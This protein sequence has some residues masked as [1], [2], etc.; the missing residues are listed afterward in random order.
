MSHPAA[1]TPLVRWAPLLACP[2]A[3]VGCGLMFGL[4]VVVL[5][6]ALAVAVSLLPIGAL[7]VIQRPALGFLLVP[8]T[9]PVGAFGVP[10]LGISTT[11]FAV[12]AAT[13][14]VS[15]AALLS[16]VWPL[17]FERELTWAVALVAWIAVATLA[18]PDLFLGVRQTAVLVAGLCLAAAIATT[19]STRDARTLLAV[20]LAIGGTICLVGVRGTSQLDVRYGGAVVLGRA[21]GIFAQ[22]ND[23][24]IFSAVVFFVALG[25]FFASRHRGARLAAAGLA[26]GSATG[27][28]LSLSRGTWIGALVGMLAFLVLMPE[29][30]RRM[31]LVGVGAISALVALTLVAP[32]FFPSDAVVDRLDSALEGNQNPY[33]TRPAIWREGWRQMTADPVFG[34]G[35][36]GF[37]TALADSK[38]SGTTG[39]ALHA[40]NVVLTVGAE[41][42]LPAVIF[43]V[44]FTVALGRRSVRC[45]RSAISRRDRALAA[46]TSSALVAVLGQGLVDFTLRNPILLGSLWFLIGVLLVLTRTAG[47][48]ISA[49]APFQASSEDFEFTSPPAPGTAESL[50]PAA[51]GLLPSVAP[52]PPPP[53]RTPGP[54]R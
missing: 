45:S 33:D 9:L 4:V 20:F 2:I 22:P 27:V 30:R 8:L 29:G 49:R 51:T 43:L 19:A 53:V 42:G 35:P 41:A 24:G 3:L 15:T 46:G 16:G 1:S 11:D 26:V 52:D 40:H 54:A 25:W 12:L 37:L 14:V 47:T 21:Q 38:A 39:N 6:P 5:G 32:P 34:S 10:A 28:M 18:A 48:S 31:V 13:A 36:G 50:P 17:R 7:M 44:A 23:F